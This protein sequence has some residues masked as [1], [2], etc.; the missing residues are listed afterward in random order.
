MNSALTPDC[1]PHTELLAERVFLP[2]RHALFITVV[3]ILGFFC[4]T[5]ASLWLGFDNPD[6]TLRDP[7]TFAV[8]LGCFWSG[9]TILS[10]FQLVAYRRMR[11]FTSS[12]VVRTIGVFR[13]RT[14][15]LA[16][17]TRAM[18]HRWPIGGLLVL[19]APRSCVVFKFINYAN[20]EELARFFRES[21]PQRVQHNFQ[22]RASVGTIVLLA[23]LGAG[24]IALAIWDPFGGAIGGGR[25]KGFCGGW[26]LLCAGWECITWWRQNNRGERG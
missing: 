13:D 25:W 15:V 11:V 14:V 8:A 16:E 3:C 1:T 5:V 4:L 18:W 2:A 12:T 19:H 9:M 7:I 24:T 21:L 10:V 17:V 6:E 26:F 20:G 22:H 23:V